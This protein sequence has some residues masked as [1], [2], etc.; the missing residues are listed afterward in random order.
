[1]SRYAVITVIAS[2]IKN[3]EKKVKKQTRVEEV[4]ILH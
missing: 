2:E 4:Q 3:Q 1:M